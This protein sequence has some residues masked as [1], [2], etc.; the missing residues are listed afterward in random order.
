MSDNGSISA[1]FQATARRYADH[2]FLHVTP[3]TA[4]YYDCE[5][6]TLTYRA[7]AQEVTQLTKRYRAAGIGGGV[8][9]GIALENR[10]EFFLHLLALNE[11][12][13][14]VV[15]L[16]VA[17]QDDELC[18]LVNHSELALLIVH[19]PFLQRFQALAPRFSERP[20]LTTPASLD[21]ITIDG[22]LCG[23]PI[24]G[25]TEAAVIYTSGTTGTPK[26]CLLSND[27]F[28]YIGRFYSEIGGLCEFREGEDRLITP[29][30]VSHMNAL[31]TSF[32]GVMETGA[33]LIQLDRFHPRSYWQTVRDSGATI[34]HY[35]GVMPAMLLNAPESSIDDIGDQI[36]F[37]FGA[38]CDP[39]H[40]AAFERRFGFPLTE[41]WAMSETG[42]GAWITASHEP[43]HVGQ[44]SFGRS[45]DGLE[46]RLVDEAGVD[47]KINE[48]GEL[49]VR[50]QGSTPRQYF[51]SGYLKDAEATEEAWAGGW[52]HTGDEVRVD[53]NGTFFFVDRRKNI[54][55]RSGENIA[56]LEVE[57]VLLRHP[58]VSNCVVAPVPDD[59]RGEEVAALIVA[60]EGLDPIALSD[61]L[62]LMASENLAYYK[63]PAYFIFVDSV[64]LTAS[65][66]VRRGDVKKLA[67][68]RVAA[69]MCQDFTHMK[70][71]PAR[72]G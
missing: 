6:H 35:L 20:I 3:D 61:E 28:R 46:Y 47:V 30:P 68:E 72:V 58:A 26:G 49:L 16:N 11:L 8:R 10:P 29:L 64:P 14:S 66:K 71:P 65:E 44:R 59:I 38:G 39:R 41:A 55:R 27:Y 18:Y 13:A 25:T 69:G 19:P 36:R 50:R 40:H 37:G 62:F 70:K 52:F 54:I 32:M 22:E 56:A 57:T 42:A 67:A 53:V 34:L 24:S 63:S 21:E 31:A 60:A 23:L 2:D 45:P 5:S 9:V 15:P 1:R 4:R 17:M 12:G 33:C 7:A 51:F 43:R 48:T